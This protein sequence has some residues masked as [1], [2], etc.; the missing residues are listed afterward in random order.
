MSQMKLLDTVRRFTG[1]SGED[2]EQWLNRFNVAIDIIEKPADNAAKNALMAKFIP[3]LLDGAAYSTWDQ[4]DGGEKNDFTTIEAA[5]RRAY[6]KTLLSAWQELKSLRLLPGEPIDVLVTRIQRLLGVVVRGKSV[7]EQMAAAFL[8]DAL[9]LRVAEQVRIQH[10]EEMELKGVV[11]C[12]KALLS[13]SETS[14]EIAAGAAST[15]RLGSST[16]SSKSPPRCFGC[17]RVG[18]LKRNCRVICYACHQR[19]HLQRD[20]RAASAGNGRAEAAAPD[21]AAPAENH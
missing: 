1:E 13:S 7:P 18:H 14:I 10:G 16:D 11:S 3:L 17:G 20:C 21:H 5:L 15:H 8:V 12:A 2:V 4:L 6:G 9:P 19:G